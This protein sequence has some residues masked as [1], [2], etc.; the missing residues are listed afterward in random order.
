MTTNAD[1]IQAKTDQDKADLDQLYSIVHKLGNDTPEA[2]WLAQFIHMH[3][4]DL[5][6]ALSQLAAVQR[7]TITRQ[8]A[9]RKLNTAHN[10]SIRRIRSM[11]EDNRKLR[12][13]VRGYEIKLGL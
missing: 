9:I 10:R 6:R 13:K 3:R 1:T 8:D 11:R 5:I 12:A 2:K 4:A 7:S